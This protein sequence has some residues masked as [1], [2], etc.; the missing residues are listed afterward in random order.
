LFPGDVCRFS[1][2]AKILIVGVLADDRTIA[3]V[4]LDSQKYVSCVAIGDLNVRFQLVGRHSRDLKSFCVDGRKVWIDTTLFLFGTIAGDTVDDGSQLFGSCGLTLYSIFDSDGRIQTVDLNRHC[5]K[6]NGNPLVRIETFDSDDGFFVEQKEEL[7]L[8]RSRGI[9]V[10]RGISADRAFYVRF[11]SDGRKARKM[12]ESALDFV[13]RHDYR[14]LTD[15]MSFIFVDGTDQRTLDLVRTPRGLGVVAGI[16]EDHSVAI[17]VEKPGSNFGTVTLF[18]P[19]VV[20]S[21]A[22]ANG[23]LTV[24]ESFSGNCADFADFGVLPGDE[25]DN[26]VT[27]V[28]V[29]DGGVYGR[30][31]AGAIVAVDLSV[32]IRVRHVFAVCEQGGE[33]VSIYNCGWAHHANGR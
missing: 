11:L 25:L 2:A 14:V 29:Q 19:S 27:V 18:D 1:G 32:G 30:N 7:V 33:Y 23:P 21:I 8:H 10:L 28:G 12:Q 6:R 5:L 22:R 31:M 17:W 26:G 16:A 4:K 20:E 9:G 15:C 3:V 24:F 13:A